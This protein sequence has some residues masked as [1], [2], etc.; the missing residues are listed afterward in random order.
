MAM[1]IRRL[2]L[3]ALRFRRSH[4][5]G[6][7]SPFAF[8]FITRVLRERAAYYDYALLPGLCPSLPRSKAR[9]LLRVVNFLQPATVWT[10]DP[11]VRAVVSK[12]CPSALFVDTPEEADLAVVTEGPIPAMCPAVIAL[13]PTRDQWNELKA[14]RTSGM[15]FTNSYTGVAVSRKGLP[16]Q[17]FSLWY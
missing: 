13:S 10:T 6:V 16:R 8:R 14:T 12:V 2:W 11:E 3:Q 1:R 9:L 17:D 7:H 5:F 15:T 4:G